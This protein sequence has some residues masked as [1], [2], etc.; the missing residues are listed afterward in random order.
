MCMETTIPIHLGYCTVSYNHISPSF[1]GAPIK[2]DHL[3]SLILLFQPFSLLHQNVSHHIQFRKP[4]LTYGSYHITLLPRYII[5]HSE[6]RLHILH[7]PPSH[8]LE[9][10]TPPCSWAWME[11]SWARL[12]CVELPA[13]YPPLSPYPWNI[14]LPFPCLLLFPFPF[15]FFPFFSFHYLPRSTS[16]SSS[17][18]PLLSCHVMPSR[19]QV[20]TLQTSHLTSSP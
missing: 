11:F 9:A 3:Q 18:L 8:V 10:R 19:K 2:T 14:S 15:P 13:L 5:V 6:Q 7:S 1:Q 4:T 12:S 17:S 20:R 16:F